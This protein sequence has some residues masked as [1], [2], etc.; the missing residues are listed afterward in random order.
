MSVATKKI[1]LIKWLSSMEDKTIIEQLD[2][3]RKQQNSFDFKK[4]IVTAITGEELK[5]RTTAFIQSLEWK[6]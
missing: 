6:K 3:F 5:K 4:E 1:E 2:N